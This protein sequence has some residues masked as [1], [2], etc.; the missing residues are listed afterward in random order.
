[1]DELKLNMKELFER[2]KKEVLV[3]VESEEA[4]EAIVAAFVMTLSKN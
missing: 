1:M 4:K 2:F 3:D